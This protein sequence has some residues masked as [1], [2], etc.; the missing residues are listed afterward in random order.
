MASASHDVDQAE[1]AE[2]PTTHEA[3]T[4]RLPPLVAFLAA[5]VLVVGLAPPAHSQPADIEA[6]PALLTLSLAELGSDTTVWFYGDTSSASLSFPVPKGLRPATLNATLD[7]PFAVASGNL[8]VLQDDRLIS[9][10]ALPPADLDPVILPLD[11]VEVIDDS[12]TV[13]LKLSALA[14]DRFCLDQENPVGLINGSL[15]YTGA[16]SAPTTV[17]DFLPPI[18]RTLTIGIPREPTQAESDAAVQLAAALQARYRGQD[19]RVL[20]LPL[21]A[22]ETTIA[23]PAEQFERRIVVKEGEQEGVSLQFGDVPQLLISGG[24]DDLTNQTRLLTDVSLNLAVSTSVV[25]GDMRPAGPAVGDSTTLAQLDAVNLSNFGV[26]PQVGLPLDQT[27]FGHSTEGF[28]VHVTGSHTPVPADVGARLTASVNGEVID[29]WGTGPDSAID[30]WVDIPD[31]LVTRYTNL[32]V[33]MDTSGNTGR[34]GEFRP[35]TLTIDGSS[36]VES[37]PAVPPVPAGFG[38][39]PQA[40][41]P[42]MQ[43]GLTPQNFADIERA[44]QIVVG[45][46]RLS[47]VPLLTEVTPIQQALDSDEPAIVISPDGWD[48]ESVPLPVSSQDRVVTLVGFGAD[49]E[50]TTLTLD[51]GMKFGSLQTVFDGQRSLLIATSNGAPAQLDELLRWLNSDPRGLAKLRGNVVVAIEGSEPQMVPDRTPVSVY[52]PPASDAQTEAQGQGGSGVSIMWIGAGVLAAVGIGAAAYL[53]GKR[54]RS[55]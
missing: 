38:S 27:R 52:G 11:T 48:N 34:C 46:Q 18:L 43:V 20:L 7:L 19:P 4:R 51:P 24:P 33:G 9:T 3:R 21:A 5:V 54:R 53:L 22:D 47:V 14:A 12:V 40:L 25:A 26:A 37:S 50:Q 23:G 6:P 28:R 13:T 39:L 17:A 55:S 35:I 32:V 29:S 16:E 10:I 31:R 42:R 30:H 1:E 49:D 45:L 41:M 44:M 8:T 36:V 2:L 15:T